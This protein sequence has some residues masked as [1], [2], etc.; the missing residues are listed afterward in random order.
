MKSVDLV[1]IAVDFAYLDE[2]KAREFS[3]VRWSEVN[4]STSNHLRR[5]RM[6]KD[7]ELLTSNTGKHTDKGKDSLVYD[8]VLL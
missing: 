3:F 6:S 2:A 8:S 1:R 7:A 5:Q 4:E